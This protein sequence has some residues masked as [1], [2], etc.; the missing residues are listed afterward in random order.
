MGARLKERATRKIYIRPFVA[1]SKEEGR[2]D[3]AG[4]RANMIYSRA[5]IHYQ[6]RELHIGNYCG[7]GIRVMRARARARS[8]GG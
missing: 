4:P 5:T 7:R 2:P 6:C 3:V 1:R 8:R